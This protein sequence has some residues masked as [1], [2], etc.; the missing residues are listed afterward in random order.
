MIK[1]KIKDSLYI[2][3]YITDNYNK[4]AFQG[5]KDKQSVLI[6]QLKEIKKVLDKYTLYYR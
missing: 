6:S 3:N 4:L 1:A 5:A 2:I